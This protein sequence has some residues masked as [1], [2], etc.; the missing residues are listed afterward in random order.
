M[1]DCISSIE[2]KLL[3]KYNIM[4]LIEFLDRYEKD[5]FKELTAKSNYYSNNFDNILKYIYA[6]SIQVYMEIYNILNTI[7]EVYDYISFQDDIFSAVSHDAYF[8]GLVAILRYDSP[9]RPCVLC[10]ESCDF[11]DSLYKFVKLIWETPVG[12]LDFNNVIQ[13]LVIIK[14]GFSSIRQDF[15]VFCDYIS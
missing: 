8:N 12:K 6:N 3:L 11:L 15:L 2:N 4:E 13:L 14:D 9:T 10:T 1:V 7:T 5:I